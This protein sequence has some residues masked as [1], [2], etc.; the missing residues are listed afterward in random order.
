MYKYVFSNSVLFYNI[1]LSMAV[2]YTDCTP[3]EG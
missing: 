2:E 1:F 3:A